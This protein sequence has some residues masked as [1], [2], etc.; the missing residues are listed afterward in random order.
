MV[1]VI[2]WLMVL[3]RVD[4]SYAYPMLSIGYIV[5]AFC[6]YAFFAENMSAV[7]WL[8]VIVICAGVFMITRTA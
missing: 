1:S 8:G 7:R 5:T 2:V 4:I 3:S 6:G